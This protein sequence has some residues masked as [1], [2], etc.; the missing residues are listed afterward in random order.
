VGPLAGLRVAVTVP[1]TSWFGGI[2][3]NFAIE[4]AEEIRALGAAVFELDVYPCWLRNQVYV[5]EAITALR[6]FRPDVAVSLPNSGYILH[7]VT[8]TGENIFTDILQVP[9]VMLWDHGLLQ[10]PKQVLD[11]LPRDPADAA[12][13]SIERLR[14]VLNHPL[15]IHYSPDRGHV[16]QM[17]RLGLI[18]PSK[19]R[20]F[21]QPAY[22]NFLRYGYGK[23]GTNAFASRVAFAGNVYIQTSESLPFRRHPKLAEVEA[24][25]LAAKKAR[26][27]ECL[28]DLLI[29]EIDQLDD[30]VVTKLKLTPDSTFFWSFL[31][32]E[33][34]FVGNTEVR[35]SVLK[36]L[37][38]EC[39]F[40][41]NFIEPDT[42]ATLRDQYRL[43]FRKCLDYFTELPLLFVNSGVIVDVV[44][45]GY[46]HGVSPKI[47]GCFACGGLVLFD[48]K[49]DFAQAMN[50]LG[51]E[52]MYRSIDHLNALVDRYLTNPRQRLDVV[53][54]L[55]HR[56]CTEFN[57]GA[58]C[59]RFL[60]E[61][62]AWRG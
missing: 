14:K 33:I 27:N 10:F 59:R 55:Q 16:E 26:L 49:E 4:M 22:P 20:L 24:R 8:P 28:W 23:A 1:P 48:Y 15:Y 25:V 47:M 54:Y 41:G 3:Y 51:S 17:G 9:A 13:G 2:D 30:S 57:F 36:G 19:V 37:Q 31:Y 50:G 42:A 46:N 44:N 12:L 40:F 34:E 29:A 56:V 18:D 52:V 43:R 5:D 32:D 39:E 11:P 60:V 45:L 62:P 21:L 58:L 6:S 7:S 38:K 61:E 35:L 53:R